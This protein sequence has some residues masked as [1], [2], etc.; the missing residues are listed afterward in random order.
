M[1]S[2]AD[3]DLACTPALQPH[4]ANGI[5]FY[6]FHRLGAFAD[7]EHA[8]FTR[9]GGV[10]APPFA[11]L[12]VSYDTGDDNARVTENLRRIQNA[13]ALPDLIYARQSH[14][15]TVAVLH[16]HPESSPGS[17]Y[18]LCGVDGLITRVP[19]LLLV[20]KVADCQAI[21]L[22]DPNKGVAANVHAGWRG[23]VQNIPGKAVQLMGVHF[24][25][26]PCDLIAA[27]C[28]SLGPC[29]A[30]FR[31]WRQE[32]PSS[33]SRVRLEN[34]HFDF[35]AVSRYQLEAA[36]LLPDNIEVAGLCTRC[37]PEIFYSYRA[38][39][40]TGRFAAVIGIKD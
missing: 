1:V 10:S 12:N 7:L 32:L 36:G 33:F 26:R 9:N 5:P 30:E 2:S 38:E 16:Q 29:C 3:T 39:E 19:G 24:G 18:P 4:R 8:V 22:Y 11:S 28:P 14:G 34:D 40:Q 27:I 25:C 17:N 6:R 35:W 20:V 21:L 37:H 23:S 31:N 15:S 13:M